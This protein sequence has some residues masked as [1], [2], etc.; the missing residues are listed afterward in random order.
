MS[1]CT[2]WIA[3]GI[4]AALGAAAPISSSARAQDANA[5]KPM[6]IADVAWLTGGW[7][8]TDGGVTIEEHWI[9]P[10][11]GTMLAVGRTTKGER[12]MFFEFLRIEQRRDSLVYVA[13][14]AGKSPGTDFTATKCE[15]NKIVFAN[16]EHDFPKSIAYELKDDGTLLAHLEGDEHGKPAREDFHYSRATK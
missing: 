9:A 8:T 15:K 10:A 4:C 3:L 11:G 1:K 14:P 7:T 12:T 16:P 6:K 13:Q 5:A 2:V